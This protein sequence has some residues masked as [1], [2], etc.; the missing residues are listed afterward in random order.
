V[1]HDVPPEC[2]R[3]GVRVERIDLRNKV[4]HTSAGEIAF[5]ALV[6]AAPFPKLLSSCGIEYDPG[7]YSYNKVLVFNL[8]FDAKGPVGVHWTYY[9]QRDVSFYRAGFYDNIFDTPAL[10][11]YVE[12]G[13]P[14][15]EVIDEAR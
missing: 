5:E 14:G 4:A 6:S 12:L 1:A 11:M 3:L 15:D 2:I 8:G 13:F 10:S 9:P 7:V